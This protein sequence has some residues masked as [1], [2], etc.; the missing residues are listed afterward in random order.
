MGPLFY[1]Y[2]YVLLIPKLSFEATHFI[3]LSK[4][5]KKTFRKIALHSAP[6]LD[7]YPFQKLLKCAKNVTKTNF[8]LPLKASD[9]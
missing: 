1:W 2:A 8:S 7:F 9:K 6:D 3:L 4:C 5:G